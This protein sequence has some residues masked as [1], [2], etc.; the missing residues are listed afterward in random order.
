MMGGLTTG[1]RILNGRILRELPSR[2]P[3]YSFM[4]CYR[5]DDYKSHACNGGIPHTFP[6]RFLMDSSMDSMERYML[7]HGM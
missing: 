4:D 1:H 7:V 5:C 2:F 3:M 6:G